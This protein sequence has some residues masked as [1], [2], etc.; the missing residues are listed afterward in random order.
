MGHTAASALKVDLRI[1]HDHLTK[2]T[3]YWEQ[4]A[5]WSTAKKTCRQ[6]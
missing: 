3:H 5:D 6:A 1:K 4:T 2:W